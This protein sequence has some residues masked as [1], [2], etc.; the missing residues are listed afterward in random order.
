LTFLTNYSREF[1]ELSTNKEHLLSSWERDAL[2]QHVRKI[3][4]DI[5][6]TFDILVFTVASL[7]D[8]RATHFAMHHP[9][10]TLVVDEAGQMTQPASILL[11]QLDPKRVVFTGDH[12]QLQPTLA[13]YAAEIAGLKFSLMEWVSQFE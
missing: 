6:K 10:T 2:E 9:V 7:V 1:L 11:T 8:V 13:S 5:M 4:W 3:E 12:K